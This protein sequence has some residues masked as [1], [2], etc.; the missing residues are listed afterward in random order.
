MS[1]NLHFVS[2]THWDRE[3]YEPFDAFRC[4][5]VQLMDRLLDILDREPRY[6]SFLLDGQ[7]IVLEDYLEIRPENRERIRR[8]VQSG[9][10]L[11][12]PWYVLP[13]EFLVSGETHIRNL[14]FGK[15][16]CRDFGAIMR[17]GYLPDSFGHIAQMPQILQKSGIEFAV[18]WR[19]VPESITTSE[20][21]WQSPDG[22]RV[23]TLYMPFGYGVATCLPEDKEQLAKRIENLVKQLS[24]F[25]TTSHLLLMNGSD[26]VE[27]DPDLPQKLDVLREVFPEYCVVHSNLP[28]LFSQI[29][30]ECKPERLPVHSGELRSEDRAY[31]LSGTLSTRVYLKQKHSTLSHCLEGQVEPLYTILHILGY[32]QYPPEVRYL[33]KLL[34]QNS[35]HDSI[36]GCSIDPVHREMFQRYS[37]IETVVTKLFQ[38]IPSNLSYCN[39]TDQE[40]YLVVFNPHPWE[41]QAYIECDVFLEKEKV[42]EVNFEE[43]KLVAYRREGREETPRS[44]QLIAPDE[45]LTPLILHSEWSTLVET[46]PHTLPEVFLA[47]KYRIAFVSSKLPPLGFKAYRIA[48]SNGEKREK[49]PESWE[50]HVLENEFYRLSVSPP[51]SLFRLED[52]QSG[53]SIELKIF[54][55]DG[56]D[57][58]D[59]YDYSPPE[60]DEIVSSLT[61]TPALKTST[62]GLCQKMTMQYELSIPASLSLDRKERSRERVPL[63]ISLE[64][65]L[66]P[67]SRQVHLNVHLENNALDHRLQML[68]ATPTE[69]ISLFSGAH[70]AMLERQPS[71]GQSMPQKDFILLRSNEWN[72]AVL[73]RGLQEFQY[74]KRN[75]E[76]V[77]AITLLRAVGWLSRDDLLT[78]KGDAGWPFPTPEAQCLGK[79]TFE[80]AL[81]FGSRRDNPWLGVQEAL[82]FNR[83]PI[84]FQVPGNPRS[85][86]L[87]GFSLLTIDNPYIVMSAL[88]KSE[89]RDD[90]VLRLYNPTPE[91][92]RCRLSFGQTVLLLKELTL[93]EE[94]LSV[95][96][97]STQTV[98]FDFEPYE[99]KTLG[100]LF[101]RGEKSND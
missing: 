99:I 27:P 6:Q 97:L 59:E 35:P 66:P 5:L 80:L 3:W 95:S 37:K 8:M 52:K 63:P 58:G 4:R 92:Q 82:L 73:N 65:L 70:F 64:I 91:K 28:Y 33:W 2:H 77:V 79:H 54:F 62:N 76:T 81:A 22:S 16:I 93:L 101:A 57:A 18:L 88:K 43:S 23:L 94:E 53:K 29:V 45:E 100:L 36:C 25:A 41:I 50:N 83:P 74:F 39:E 69:G 75:K 98:E 71:F 68:F 21:Y 7:T 13:D 89:D 31:L 84:V 67:G 78:R 44:L 51:E 15:S 32:R 40:G 46:P 11:I 14:L 42:K 1:W 86:L 47:R 38:G 85:P 56:G 72:L 17:I 20:F 96:P 90:V 19:G 12:G 61:T 49:P 87:R 26:H 60:K 9:R 10:M 24:P 48:L 34:L 55:E 30:K